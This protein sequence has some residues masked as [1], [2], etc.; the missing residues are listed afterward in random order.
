M[1]GHRRSPLLNQHMVAVVMAVV[2]RHIC[3][4]PRGHN[5]TKKEP[6]IAAAAAACILLRT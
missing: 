1:L 4:E 5:Y 6:H 3:H 2:G